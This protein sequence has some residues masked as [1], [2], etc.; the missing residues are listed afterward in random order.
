MKN[1]SIKVNISIFLGNFYGKHDAYAGAVFSVN[2]LSPAI[3]ANSGGNTQP[4][5]VVKYDRTEKIG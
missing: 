3:K 4:M 1:K 2:G 5:V